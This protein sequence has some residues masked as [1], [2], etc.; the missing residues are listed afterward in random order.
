MMVTFGA[1]GKIWGEK[2]WKKG[3][4]S[5]YLDNEFMEVAIKKMFRDSKNNLGYIVSSVTSSEIWLIPLMVDLQSY[6]TE[7]KKKKKKKTL[8]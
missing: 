3:Q 1:S 4:K 7:L 8:G 5:P 2:K 6:W